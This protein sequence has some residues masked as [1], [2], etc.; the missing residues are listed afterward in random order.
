[1]LEAADKWLGAARVAHPRDL[2]AHQMFG[3]LFAAAGDPVRARWHLERGSLRIAPRAPW[4]VSDP[5]ALF[6][7]VLSE[8]VAQ[9]AV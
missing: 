3:Y 2:E 4:A 1:M 6:A 8:V 9:P 5:G 7:R